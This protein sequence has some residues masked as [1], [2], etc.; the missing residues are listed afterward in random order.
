MSFDQFPVWSKALLAA[1]IGGFA[2]AAFDALIVQ[3]G[4][5]VVDYKKAVVSGL[6]GGVVAALSYV[7]PAP[8]QVLKIVLLGVL[9]T[10][11]MAISC[12]KNSRSLAKLGYEINVGINQGVKTSVNLKDQGIIFKD[13]DAGYRGWLK[14]LA[15]IQT[16]SD[17]L[18]K[19]LDQMALLDGTSKQEIL[20]LIDKVAADFVTARRVGTIKLPTEAVNTILIGQALLNGARIV[21][22][23]F[24]SGKPKQVNAIRYVPVEVKN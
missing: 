19:R 4:A 20:T 24:D 9:T 14:L 5:P 10:S 22:A 7:K 15:D 23:N 16:N 6:F 18:N 17:E 3:Q 2:T 13:D 1:F 8:N 12:S 21:V 11:T